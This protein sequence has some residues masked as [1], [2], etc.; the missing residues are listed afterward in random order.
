MKKT[1]LSI[2]DPNPSCQEEFLA[3]MQMHVIVSKKQSVKVKKEEGWYS[4]S[5]MKDDLGWSKYEPHFLK[6]IQFFIFSTL[7]M[8]LI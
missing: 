3:K 8:L 6:H 4:E 2:F 1:T 7:K 5:E